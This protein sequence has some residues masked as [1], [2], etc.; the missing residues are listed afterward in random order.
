MAAQAAA[1]AHAATSRNARYPPLLP[2]EKFGEQ[3]LLIV[4]LAAQELLFVDVGSIQQPKE[5]KIK[6]VTIYRGS[7][8]EITA[9]S[10][11][12]LS[13]CESTPCH[14]ICPHKHLFF[15]TVHDS[16]NGDSSVCA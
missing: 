1:A 12:N 11:T 6:R 3:A 4:D 16:L 2:L 13:Q 5:K 15:E 10:V 9:T 7:R 8:F 14:S